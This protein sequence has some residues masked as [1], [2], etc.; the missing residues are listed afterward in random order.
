MVSPSQ[1]WWLEQRWEPR[2]VVWRTEERDGSMRIADL[3]AVLVVMTCSSKDKG[4]SALVK[5]KGRLGQFR[6]QRAKRPV[7]ELESFGRCVWRGWV[8]PS[9]N[10][11][12]DMFCWLLW[13]LSKRFLGDHLILIPIL[14]L[15]YLGEW[16]CLHSP[17][18]NGSFRSRQTMKGLLVAVYVDHVNCKIITFTSDHA[19]YPLWMHISGVLF[20]ERFSF[21]SSTLHVFFISKK[22]KERKNCENL[23]GNVLDEGLANFLW[24][25]ASVQPLS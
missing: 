20:G 13:H 24:P 16:P 5:Q 7:V 23:P 6:M 25:N 22:R 21:L 3:R 12:I 14:S 2:I 19:L 11:Q 4:L 9:Y 8:C 10:D 17:E 15:E 1:P 18:G